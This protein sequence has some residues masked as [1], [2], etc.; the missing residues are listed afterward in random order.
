MTVTKLQSKIVFLCEQGVIE[1][2]SVR[3]RNVEEKYGP[4]CVDC[5]KNQRLQNQLQLRSIV[6]QLKEEKVLSVGE[7]KKFEVVGITIEKLEATS[8]SGEKLTPRRSEEEEMKFEVEEGPC[9]RP[10]QIWR[11][12]VEKD[13]RGLGVRRQFVYDRGKC[14]GEVP[15]SARNHFEKVYVF[16]AWCKSR[17][18]GFLFLSLNQSLVWF[19]EGR[20]Y[21]NRMLP[22]CVRDQ[23]CSLVTDHVRFV[24]KGRGQDL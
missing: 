3:M 13:M 6:Q 22:S 17:H 8:R 9:C 12:S 10:M 16:V 4:S 5:V 14:G 19:S 24:R 7:V 23:A 18:C 2:K 21:E 1:Q 15:V 20:Y 11:E